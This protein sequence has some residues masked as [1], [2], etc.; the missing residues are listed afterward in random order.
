MLKKSVTKKKYECGTDEAGRGSLA[1]PVTAAAVILPNGF[2]N[3]W[4]TDSKKLSP[5]KRND[6]RKIILNEAVSYGVFH[7]TCQE[8]D[9]F[10]ILN[11]SIHAMHKAIDQLPKVNFIAVDGNKFKKYHDIPFKT[12][13]KGDSKYLNI[14]AA[15][16]L[17]KTFRDDL[18]KKIHCEFPMYNWWGNKGYPTKEHKLAITKYGPSKYHRK[19]F[20]LFTEQLN[21]E[22]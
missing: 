2:K 15:S 22:F 13:I 3:K 20:K 10:N 9:K 8:I 6:L 18:M 17:A 1:G 4:I 11:A 16:I 21:F 5:N 14:A 12:I 7:V 19:S